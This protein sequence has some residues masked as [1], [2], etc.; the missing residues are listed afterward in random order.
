MVLLLVLEYLQGV[1]LFLKLLRTKSHS[2]RNWGSQLKIPN[3]SHKSQL[4]QLNWKIQDLLP[5]CQCSPLP[6]AGPQRVAAL[7]SVPSPLQQQQNC[8]TLMVQMHSHIKWNSSK[9]WLVH[10]NKQI[11]KYILLHIIICIVYT[12]YI[13]KYLT[14]TG[15][16]AEQPRFSSL[17]LFSHQKSEPSSSRAA[18]FSKELS[19]SWD[20]ATWAYRN[21]WQLFT[22]PWVPSTECL[23]QMMRKLP[24]TWVI[25]MNQH[26]GKDHQLWQTPYWKP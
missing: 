12:C 21:K 18:S 11:T 20:F 16:K 19:S 4:L 26:L 23:D 22:E 8:G 2:I 1:P 6:F 3:A 15:M 7:P 5:G 13:Y 14:W 9:A 10:G 25:L 24:F 17:K